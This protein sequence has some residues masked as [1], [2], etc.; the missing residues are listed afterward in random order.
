MYDDDLEQ[1]IWGEL[2]TVYRCGTRDVSRDPQ[3]S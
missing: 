1:A 3:L 2:S